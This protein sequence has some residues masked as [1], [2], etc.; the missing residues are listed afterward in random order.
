MNPVNNWV[1][2]YPADDNRVSHF[3]SGVEVHTASSRDK[4]HDISDIACQTRSLFILMNNK[5][6]SI[7][8]IYIICKTNSFKRIYINRRIIMSVHATVNTAVQTTVNTNDLKCKMDLA[9]ANLPNNHII[10]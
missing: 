4:K 5:R 7:T 1:L 2:C 8:D 10:T 6:F 3:T 9:N